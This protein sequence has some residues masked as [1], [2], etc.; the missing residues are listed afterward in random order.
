MNLED[1]IADARL[2]RR[3][4]LQVIGNSLTAAGS[5]ALLAACAKEG[6]DAKPATPPP[7]AD[8]PA[9]GGELNCS[10]QGG[11]DDAS[12]NMRK[13]LQYMEK[14]NKP[15]KKLRELLAVRSQHHRRTLRR[16]Q[17][18]HW[19]RQPERELLEPRAH[20]PRIV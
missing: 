13:T 17:T 8:K 5:L 4:A 2:S 14:S 11:I 6:G 9:A 3:R 15:G 10:T 18:L 12:K 7:A 1:L 16:L 20:H 19:P